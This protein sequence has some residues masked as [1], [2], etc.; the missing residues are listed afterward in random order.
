MA[1]KISP[2]VFHAVIKYFFFN[3]TKLVQPVHLQVGKCKLFH[4]LLWLDEHL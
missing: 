2:A 3:Q 1:N 4:Q